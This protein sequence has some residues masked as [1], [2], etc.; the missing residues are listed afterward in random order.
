M[1]DSGEQP[2]FEIQSIIEQKPFQSPQ[3]QAFFSEWCKV[4]DSIEPQMLSRDEWEQKRTQGILEE[5]PDEK[6]TLFLPDDLHLWEMVGVMEVID[7]DTFASK[8]ERQDEKKDEVLALGRLFQNAGRYIIQRIDS[9]TEGQEIAQALAE[10]F[11]QYG[12]SLESQKQQDQLQIQDEKPL[13]AE[14]TE[15]I[16]H[17]LA[18]ESLYKSRRTR[19]ETTS[20]TDPTKRDE[21]YESQR[22]K[23]L[24]QFFR[25]SKHALELEEKSRNKELRPSENT[26]EPWQSNM[27]IHS[28][29]LAKI[30]QSLA[31]EIETPKRELE[32]AIFR[33]GV[34]KLLSGVKEK[35]R[36]VSK[37]PPFYN[38]DL[39]HVQKSISDSIHLSELRKRLEHL[40]KSDCN[41]DSVSNEE[42]L[43]A[44][45]IQ[46]TVAKL[47]YQQTVHT[48]AEMIATQSLNCVGASML[49]GALLRE[50][51]LNYLVGEIP[52]HSI[53]FL[54]TANGRLESLD[55]LNMP[56]YGGYTLTDD[57]IIETSRDE[58]PLT[59]A[60]IIEFSRLPEPKNLTFDLDTTKIPNH[61]IPNIPDQPPAES[62]KGG[63]QITLFKPEYGHQI[64]VLYS[65]A[66][67]LFSLGRMEEA[68]EASRQ[69]LAIAPKYANAYN[70]LGVSLTN[71]D[72][73]DEAVEVFRQ[74]L[75][76]NPDS[77]LYNGLANTLFQ[78]GRYEESI[79]VLRKAIEIMPNPDAEYNG[80]G[81]ALFALGKKEEAIEAYRHGLA[82][83]STTLTRNN[84]GNALVD[85]ERYDEAIIEFRQVLDTD[86]QNLSA[87]NGLGNALG[88]L[89]R[90]E[91][92]LSAYNKTIAIDP[93]FYPP[94]LGQG[95]VL[96][97]LGRTDEA[98]SAFRKFISLLDETTDSDLIEQAKSEIFKLQKK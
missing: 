71:L 55:M 32:A 44:Q 23:T 46:L 93:S 56:W 90:N 83:F 35:N 94:Y 98:I 50:A 52:Y 45:D 12:K 24:S 25:T 11:Y 6:Q 67:H 86:P 14:E 5:N 13:T 8:P 17:F 29:F 31:R 64:Q 7:H 82:I 97:D 16:D 22:R 74:G 87:L 75:S 70:V 89:N 47:N 3:V 65:T 49:G 88:S 62:K 80:L 39:Q 34:E 51:G 78:L 26:L 59:T 85:L 40:R 54:I 58:T 92:A 37:K 43:I 60:D 95:M 76:Y 9:V 2:R 42:Q 72:R 77:I 20:I 57:K 81:L 4:N 61:M 66:I 79:T 91:E 33:R 68:I 1:T 53:L 84:L 73:N 36:E 63:L 19:A 28:S 96:A 48:P 21:F 41:V 38:E 10:E 27:P 18:G 30:R 69:I 15:E